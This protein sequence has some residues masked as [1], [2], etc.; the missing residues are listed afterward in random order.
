MKN[1]N[2][3]YQKKKI[4]RGYENIYSKPSKLLAD[5]FNGIAIDLDE[6]YAHDS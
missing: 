3:N 4:Q 5:F 1:H 6:A 2:P